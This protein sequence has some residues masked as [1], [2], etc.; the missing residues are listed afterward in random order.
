VEDLRPGLD[1]IRRDFAV[2]KG[3][4]WWA[5]REAEAVAAGRRRPALGE[6]A[7]RDERHVPLMTIDPPG[8]KDLDQGFFAERRPNGYRVRYAI[9]DMAAFVSAGGAIDG[10]AWR[11]GQTAYL[12]DGNAP[13]YPTRLS[14]DVGSLLPDDDRPALMWTIDLDFGGEVERSGL[15]RA[16]VRNRR[17]L[18]YGG[19]QAALS[20]GKADASLKLLREIGQ[21]LQHRERQ[22]DGISLNL[23][24]R[25][26]VR[27]ARG[28]VFRYE[29]V[30]PVKGWNAQI[31]LLAGH[32][33]ATIMAEG[34]I[35]ILRTL[36]PVGEAHVGRLLRVARALGI[37]WPPSVSLGDVVRAEDGSSPESAAFLTQVT[38]V[39]RGAAY[40]VVEAVGESPP[41]HGALRMI[42]AH[43]TAPLR[44]LADRYA[45]EIV[46]ALCADRPVPEWAIEALPRLPETMAEAHNRSDAVEAAVLH[47]AEVVVLAPQVGR[48]FSAT[49]VDLKKEERATIMVRDPPVVAR[50]PGKGF[51]LGETIQV[52]LE[53]ADPTQRKVVFEVA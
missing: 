19:V 47:L 49:V 6:E 40:T 18:S 10:E 38:H 32:C 43:V 48:T 42:Y 46:V 45:N 3:F 51:A 7:R 13:L 17:A 41:I 27:T 8:S 9:A 28:Y 12:P 14:E 5:E 35:E 11:R 22:R 4:P 15:E 33:A 24:K 16:I 53:A 23:P 21:V 20:E 52:R 2:P 44:R 36:P 39:L 30:L 31:S 29:P 26:L 25:E 37:G 34:G 50:M 1:Q